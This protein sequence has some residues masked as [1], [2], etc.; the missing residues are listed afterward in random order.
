M[1]GWSGFVLLALL[2]SVLVSAEDEDKTIVRGR[3]EVSTVLN[4]IVFDCYATTVGALFH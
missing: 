1:A 2:A 4:P 3:V